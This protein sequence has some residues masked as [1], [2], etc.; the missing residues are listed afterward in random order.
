M[1]KLNSH[2]NPVLAPSSE[3]FPAREF[4]FEWSFQNDE[5]YCA[6]HFSLEPFVLERDISSLHRWI[7][8]D[9]ARYWGMQGSSLEEVSHCYQK[10]CNAEA[11]YAG[12]YSGEL[13]FIVEVYDPQRDL[14]RYYYTHQQGDLGMHILLAPA[15]Q[16]VRH[17]SRSVF[18]GVMYG[19][20]SMPQVQRVVVEPDARNEKIHRLNRLAG[21][22]YHQL[23]YLPHKVACLASATRAQFSKSCPV[24][25]MP[26]NPP[27]HRHTVTTTKE[28]AMNTIESGF[29]LSPNLSIATQIDNQPWLATSHLQPELWVHVNRLLVRK[30]ISEFCHESLLQPQLLEREGDWSIYELRPQNH[31]QL[32]YRFKARLLSL[33]HWW[34]ELNS[35][36]KQ[37]IGSSPVIDSS[38]I[39]DRFLALDALEFM[40]EFQKEL[41]IATDK[42]PIY[43]EE[44]SNTL[45]GS[46]YKHTKLGVSARELLTAG[47]QQIEA[48]MM[49]GHPA[50]V[51]NNGRVGFDAKD[52]RTYSPE[53]NYSFKP[54]WIAA[55]KH[56]AHFACSAELDYT[57]L[58]TS[59][60]DEAILSQFE[61]RLTQL[62]KTHADY[63][64]MP[65]HPWQWFNKISSIFA[66]EIANQNIICLGYAKDRYQAQQSIRTLFNLDKPQRHYIKMSL[67]I[68]NMGFMRGLSPYYMRGTPAINDWVYQLIS[69]DEFLQSNGFTMLR[70][71]ASVGYIHRYYENI[72]ARDTAYKKM[73]S[74]LWRESPLQYVGNGERLMTM[75]A[76]L[77]VDA[78]GNS[79]LSE[80][81]QSSGV[82]TSV[83]LKRYL[84]AYLTPLVHCFYTHDLVFMPHGENIILV[85][86]NN[87][88]VRAIMK[89]IA[90]EIAIM[91]TTS[92]LPELV[93]RV[94]V[95]VPEE[96]KVLSIFIDVFDGF[97][98]YLA[99]LLEEHMEFSSANFWQLVGENIH[100]Y[101]AQH[102]DLKAK[103]AQY[104][105]F[106]PRFAHSC[107]NRLQL[108]NNQQMISDLM[109]FSHS[110]QFA[111][112]LQNPLAA[113]VPA[114]SSPAEP[115]LST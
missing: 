103:F 72:A 87:V 57:S 24:L 31:N 114:V 113:F 46:A 71:L 43:L 54:V 34:I 78:Q 45:Y 89:D 44:I 10:L 91:N 28:L 101:Q 53:A 29:T 2:N 41:G 12:F 83:W 105:F 64:F 55:H 40:N 18:M 20:F 77:Y 21:F 110:L 5:Q 38:P 49:E 104:D 102:P 95:R 107:L 80:L 16:P 92:E 36:T 60:L 63:V 112:E 11:V 50:F 1:N 68:I 47:F 85:L 56:Q 33:N 67:S 9:Y 96:M 82:S 22:A 79:L 3:V 51:A 23:V 76:L 39:I 27:I 84:Q 26:L 70:E 109:D 8:M 74:C 88:P 7:N 111:G 75:A 108:V 81:I 35:I 25:P 90:E 17:F 15:V 4:H 99:Q 19:L 62:G 98:R 30:A 6:G 69:R 93:N 106:A 48:A 58:I 59:E 65:V 86:D 94:Q 61:Q 52:F 73:L 115:L 66:A 32:V 37:F 100:C 13:A 14:L 42:L 97:F